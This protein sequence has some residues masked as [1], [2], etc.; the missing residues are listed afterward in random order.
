MGAPSVLNFNLDQNFF[1]FKP[2]DRIIIHNR[3]FELLWHGNGRWTW[4]DIYNLPIP[5]RRL[6]ITNT[7]KK[8]NPDPT[9]EQQTAEQKAKEHVRLVNANL[10]R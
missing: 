1:G 4:S 10:S 5:L 2:E 7:N 9:V 8:I 6:W 3:L